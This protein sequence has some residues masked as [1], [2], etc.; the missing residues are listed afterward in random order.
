MSVE[1]EEDFF[2]FFNFT[3]S[4]T[5]YENNEA[6]NNRLFQDRGIEQFTNTPDRKTSFEKYDPIFQQTFEA[7]NTKPEGKVY[8]VG[9]FFNYYIKNND[10]R[11]FE[12]NQLGNF[13]ILQRRLQNK[14]DFITTLKAND[15]K[16]ILF[17]LST[18][19]IDQTPEQSLKKKSADFEALLTNNKALKLLYTDNYMEATVSNGEIKKGF[20][21]GKATKRRGRFVLWEIN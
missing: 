2:F 12:D 11:V 17:D 7:M 10:T 15:F 19:A 3:A 9:T 16:Y 18:G 14:Q 13:D 5:N 6:I 1:E 4:L 8:R 20:G 21:L